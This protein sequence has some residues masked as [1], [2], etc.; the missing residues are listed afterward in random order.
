MVS[1]Y[2]RAYVL[3]YSSADKS[4]ISSLL[5]IVYADTYVYACNLMDGMQDKEV[6]YFLK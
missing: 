6:T 2:A 5:F 4:N 1:A 3:A